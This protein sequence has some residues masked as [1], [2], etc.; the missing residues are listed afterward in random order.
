VDIRIGKYKLSKVEATGK[1][2][3]IETYSA[4]NS[5]LPDQVDLEAAS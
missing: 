5:P 4:Q 3:Q 1:E 2:L